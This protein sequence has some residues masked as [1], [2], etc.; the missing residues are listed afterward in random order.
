MEHT[1]AAEA[2]IAGVLGDAGGDP[3]VAGFVLLLIIEGLLLLSGDVGLD[4][5]TSQFLVV[6]ILVLLRSL[7]LVS[8]FE[9]GSKLPF[10]PNNS[11]QLGDFT[12]V[13][14]VLDGQ[15]GLNIGGTIVKTN[16]LHPIDTAL[17]L[18]HVGL[19][20]VWSKLE[21]S[22]VLGAKLGETLDALCL[23]VASEVPASH[24]IFGHAGRSV[25]TFASIG[26]G[27][28]GAGVELL[29]S[30][31]SVLTNFEQVFHPGVSFQ[32][33]TAILASIDND[34]SFY[35]LLIDPIK[36]RITVQV[37]QGTNLFFFLGL[38][39]LVVKDADIEHKPDVVYLHLVFVLERATREQHELDL[40]VVD[41]IIDPPLE[42]LATLLEEVITLVDHDQSLRHQFDDGKVVGVGDTI[43]GISQEVMCEEKIKAVFISLGELRVGGQNIALMPFLV[44]PVIGVLD[45]M[46]GG[47]DDEGCYHVGLADTSL[48]SPHLSG[49]LLD[50]I[51]GDSQ[52]Q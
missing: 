11:D 3:T 38:V 25:T 21:Q 24:A 41:D 48:G 40:L 14:L 8:S 9:I 28:P 27:I 1:F 30:I 6:L 5:A 32:G 36:S 42:F 52:S 7:L 26:V 44:D 23:D 51:V 45:I 18:D 20:R 34:G 49:A 33:V 12:V 19:T 37:P 4:G 43:R 46:P 10:L 2:L 35:G 17:C 22:N 39:W 13:F 15:V 29:H 16:V 47:Q 31:A 50:G